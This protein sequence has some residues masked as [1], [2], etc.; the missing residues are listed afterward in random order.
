M[1][2]L[3]YTKAYQNLHP[4]SLTKYKWLVIFSKINYIYT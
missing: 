2:F 1:P 4:I 3:P